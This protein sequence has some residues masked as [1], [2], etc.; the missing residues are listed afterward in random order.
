MEPWAADEIPGGCA[1]VTSDE[2]LTEATAAL[3]RTASR[4]QRKGGASRMTSK[5]ED[6]LFRPH[7]KG[8]AAVESPKNNGRANDR[9]GSLIDF[10]SRSSLPAQP[11]VGLALGFPHRARGENEGFFVPRRFSEIT[12]A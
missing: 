3:S 1:A 11:D 2:S 12:R 7:P 8:S 5:P 4:P 10:S 6:L 9:M